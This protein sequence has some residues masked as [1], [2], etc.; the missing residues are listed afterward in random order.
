[1]HVVGWPSCTWSRGSRCRRTVGFWRLPPPIRTVGRLR[2][3]GLLRSLVVDGD[4]VGTGSWGGAGSGGAVARRGGRGRLLL[5]RGK[6]GS[7]ATLGRGR[8]A[9]IARI[10]VMLLG[11]G[12]GVSGISARRRR[13]AGARADRGR[14]SGRTVVARRGSWRSVVAVGH[15]RARRIAFHLSKREKYFLTVYCNYYRNVCTSRI[16]SSLF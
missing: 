11:A 15:T 4:A 7:G 14:H 9:G 10:H 1:M 16:F 5:L 2:Q 3:R 12:V 8:T 13:A 6:G